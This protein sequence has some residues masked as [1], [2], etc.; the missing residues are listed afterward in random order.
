MRQVKS[1]WRLQQ[2]NEATWNDASVHMF[3]HVLI[4]KQW[5]TQCF[6][7]KFTP[8]ACPSQLDRGPAACSTS[9]Q[10]LSQCRGFE[11]LMQILCVVRS[12]M[13]RA[14]YSN[15]LVDWSVEVIRFNELPS[16]IKSEIE[17]WH[18]IKNDTS[19]GDPHDLF[20]DL[21]PLLH[22]PHPRQVQQCS[23]CV[24]FH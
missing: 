22:L 14:T 12:N 18:A 9:F 1:Q 8:T 6:F 21:V 10:W 11:R 15:Y 16:F 7:L 17:D 2:R 13:I 19:W 3:Y 23:S 4:V 5:S 20:V 24:S